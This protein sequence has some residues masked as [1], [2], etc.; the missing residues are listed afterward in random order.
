M[1]GCDGYADL[2]ALGDVDLASVISKVPMQR[3][4]DP[5][6]I[7]EVVAFLASDR[8][9]NCTGSYIAVDGG[10]IAGAPT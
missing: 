10:Y 8:A 4:A 6:E 2:S 9:S 7:A 1:S 5:A 3:V